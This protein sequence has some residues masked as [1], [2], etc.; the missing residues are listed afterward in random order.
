LDALVRAV[1]TSATGANGRQKG[2]SR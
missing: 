1:G 2:Q